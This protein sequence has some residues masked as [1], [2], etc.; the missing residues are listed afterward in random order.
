MKKVISG[1]ERKRTAIGVE[2]VTDPD[3]LFLDE[4]T[5][6]LDSFL[7]LQ[8]CRILKNLARKE[9]KIILSTIHQPNS[10]SFKEFDR[11]ILMCDGNFVF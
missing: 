8:L 6:G 5:S 3:I 4:A 7:A 2:M 11:A 10:A 1:G 9:N